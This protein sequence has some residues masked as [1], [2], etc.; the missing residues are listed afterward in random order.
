MKKKTIILLCAL[1]LSVLTILAA[2]P[3]F[4]YICRPVSAEDDVPAW[5]HVTD[6]KPFISDARRDKLLNKLAHRELKSF[7][8]PITVELM[9]CELVRYRGKETLWC[10]IRVRDAEGFVAVLTAFIQPRW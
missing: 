9:N 10:A 4:R 2:A 6:A 7:R 3:S 1:I 5:E 8:D